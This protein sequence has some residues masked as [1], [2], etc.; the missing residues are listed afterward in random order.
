MNTN[1]IFYQLFEPQSSTYTY[2]L[3]DAAKKV[4]ILIDPVLETVSRDLKL[5]TELGLELKLV[6][7][8]HI[9]ADHITG[10]GEL[11][12]RTGCQIGLAKSA[13][14]RADMQLVEGQMIQVGDISLKVLATPGHTE[15]CLSFYGHD[16]VFTGDA[17]MIRG[18]GRT[19][20]QQGSAARLYRS[21]HEQLFSLPVSTQ[22]YPAHDYN[23]FTF[24]TI[25][26]ERRLNPR[27]GVERNEADFIKLMAELQLSPPKR[28]KQ[29]VPANLNLGSKCGGQL[30]KPKLNQNIP[31]IQANEVYENLGQDFYLV[32]VRRP[33]EFN[34]ELGHIKGAQLVTLGPELMQFLE[35][36]SPNQEVVF[37]CRSGGRSGQATA[38]S[39]D[40]GYPHTMNMVGGMLRWNE[41]K[42]PVY[43]DAMDA[44]RQPEEK[45]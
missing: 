28:I 41:L 21:V 38:L 29:A 24:S 37:V 1:L 11:K 27:L 18:C 20:F 16:R 5:L 32:D 23:G 6:L 22:V 2:L 13:K 43:R 39:R 19:D 14:T 25:D 30:L 7:E 9:H 3:A 4:A 36:T 44:A 12:A 42:L 34:G 31:E 45:V 35:T 40:F 15:T 33:E 10:A 8:T 26:L 17:L